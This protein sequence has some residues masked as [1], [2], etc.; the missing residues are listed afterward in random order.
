MPR[1][2]GL[3]SP[4]DKTLGGLHHLGRMLDKIRLMQAGQLPEDFHRNYG[5]SVGLDG[6]LCGFLNVKFEDVAARVQ[7]GGADE[8]VAEWVFVRGLR[9]NR[10]Q[11]QVWNEHARKLGWTI[12]S[13]PICKSSNR[14]QAWARWWQRPRLISLKSV[15]SASH[16]R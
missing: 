7:E 4:Y 13:P 5:L 1:V 11:T 14:S 2:E 3:R 15:T 6:Q 8:E 10:M 16:R 9:P 12:A